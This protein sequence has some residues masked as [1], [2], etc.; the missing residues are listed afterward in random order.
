MISKKQKMVIA[1]LSSLLP[2][3]LGGCASPETVKPNIK[4]AVAKPGNTYVIQRASIHTPATDR[5]WQQRRA[6]R[7]QQLAVKRAH[8]LAAAKQRA[9][10]RP[11]K[12][13][14]RPTPRS[15][16]SANAKKILRQQQQSRAQYQARYQAKQLAAIKLRKAAVSTKKPVPA[17]KMPT[18][19][20]PRVMTASHTRPAKNNTRAAQISRDQL[21]KNNARLAQAKA[22]QARHTAQLKA[23][24]ARHTAQKKTAPSMR[25]QYIQR[26]EQ[27]QAKQKLER[28]IESKKA[29]AR[30]E[31]VIHNAKKQIGT[32]Y[33]WGG[34]SPKTG[35]DCS[36]LVQHSM[37]K[38]AG[39]KVPR[40]AAEQYK[41]A[42]KVSA[43]KASRGDLVF[44]KTR[45][46]SVS[47]VGIYL[48]ENKFVHA[49]RTGRK[50]TTTQ[51]SGYWKQRF[52]G[53]GRIP[54][55]CKVPV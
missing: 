51:L 32:Q 44:F 48:G 52:V 21:A 39:V 1:G 9:P 18:Q 7:N 40:T 20:K 37:N 8:L 6:A 11:A 43:Q 25:Q 33:V 35:F 54:G 15:N 34:A 30:V 19:H 10:A 12:P 46:N 17:R 49:P 24:R 50:I 42:V 41:A 4:T 2:I 5:Q 16:N 38:G 3:I 45:G 14:A 36:G 23:N 22:N 13:A 28:E 29:D 53:F 27:Q 31:S 47:H 55:A 26:W